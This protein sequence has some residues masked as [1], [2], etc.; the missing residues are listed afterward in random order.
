MARRED[1]IELTPEQE[2]EAQRIVEV[3]KQCAQEELANMARLMASKADHELFGE[4]EFQLRDI[5]HRLG[6][7]VMET[8]ANE[9]RKKGLSR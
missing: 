2:A 8:A 3:A 7:K 9:R 5:V 4:T 1:A 6:A